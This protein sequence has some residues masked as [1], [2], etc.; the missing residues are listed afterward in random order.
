MQQ[1]QLKRAQK[2]EQWRLQQENALR[3]APNFSNT[4]VILKQ[5]LQVKSNCLLH[6]GAVVFL[7]FFNILA[8]SI[9]C[10][11][12]WCLTHASFTHSVAASLGSDLTYSSFFRML[13]TYITQIKHIYAS[14][15]LNEWRFP[16]YWMIHWLL[17]DLVYLY[18]HI[19]CITIDGVWIGKW[20][21]DYLYTGLRTTSN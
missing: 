18:C 19:V 11:I 20:I 14:M 6:V 15:K 3:T 8:H 21:V 12:N 4:N 1:E 17:S 5:Y 7:Y 13:P 9:I 2:Q 16:F 10:W